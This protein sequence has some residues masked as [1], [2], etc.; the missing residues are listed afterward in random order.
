MD[1]EFALKKRFSGEL[2]EDYAL[3]ELAYPHFNELQEIVA[4]EL[5]KR[6]KSKRG[7][8]LEI[9][10]GP[11]PTS[12]KVLEKNTEI[13][14]TAMD[15]EEKMIQQ[16]KK[17]LEKYSDRIDLV[18]ADAL[19]FLESSKSSSYDAIISGW[20]LHN[21]NDEYRDKV[22]REIHRVLKQ[23]GVFINGDKYSLDNLE[24]RYK[25]FNWSIQQFLKVYPKMKRED[26]CY[27]WII[28]MSE[29]EK[30]GVIMPEG[31]ALKIMARLG[32]KNS[33]IIWRKHMEAILTA[34]K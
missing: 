14:L 1:K 25:E 3:F 26:Y 16:A 2:G 10:C 8:V 27:T 24:E 30:P 28:H 17:Y 9:G 11:G 29:D 22:L 13:Y 20:T 23:G 31:N 7:K 18:T 32:F 21:F 12:I 5:S 33:K 15:N 6:L 19:S 34:V 4:E